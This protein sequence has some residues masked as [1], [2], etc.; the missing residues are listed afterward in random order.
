MILRKCSSRQERRRNLK[1]YSVMLFYSLGYTIKQHYRVGL[2]QAFEG[3]Y[4][5]DSDHDVVVWPIGFF[6]AYLF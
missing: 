1:Q 6:F 4:G 2:F 3:L 5:T